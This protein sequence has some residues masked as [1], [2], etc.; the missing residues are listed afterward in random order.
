MKEFGFDKYWSNIFYFNTNQSHLEEDFKSAQEL[1]EAREAEILQLSDEVE[2]SPP[3]P[4]AT[5]VHSPAL[6]LKVGCRS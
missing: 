1:L 3:V 6:E 5:S 4:L 2:D